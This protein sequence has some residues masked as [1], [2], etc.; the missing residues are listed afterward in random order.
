MKAIGVF[1]LLI[2]GG[3]F[4]FSNSSSNEGTYS[5]NQVYESNCEDDIS[6][7]TYALEEANSNIE[8]ANSSIENAQYS[9][10]ETYNEMGDALDSLEQIDV[11]DEPGYSDECEDEIEDYSYALEEANANIEEVNSSIEDAQSYTW[12]TYEEMGDAIDGLQTVDT[13]SET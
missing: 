11:V 3:W 12:E 6:E 4:L 9:A 2:I 1:I 5:G 7:Y 10:W 13:V 8:T